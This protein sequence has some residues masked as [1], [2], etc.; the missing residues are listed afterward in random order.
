MHLK[1]VEKRLLEWKLQSACEP[2]QMNLIK[3]D[4]KMK[5]GKRRRLVCGYPGVY[6]G[7]TLIERVSR[8]GSGGVV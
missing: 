3:E 7:F 1:G 5:S 4:K 6:R 2:K 8:E